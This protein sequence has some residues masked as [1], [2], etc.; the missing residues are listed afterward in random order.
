MVKNSNYQLFNSG[1]YSQTDLAAKYNV[2][3]GLISNWVKK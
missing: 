2:I 1:Q 3:T